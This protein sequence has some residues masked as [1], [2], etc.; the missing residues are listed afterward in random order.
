MT[1][2]VSDDKAPIIDGALNKLGINGF[3]LPGGTDKAS[4]H[5]YGPVYEALLKLMPLPKNV[6]EVGVFYGGSLLLWQ[7]VFPKAQIVGIDCANSIHP[8]VSDR[9]DG[10]RT[11]FLQGNAYEQT[12][13]EKVAEHVGGTID[14]AIDDGPHTLESQQRFL[15]LYGPLLAP[16]GIAIVED[17]VS[18]SWLPALQAQVPEGWKWQAIDLRDKKGRADDIMFVMQRPKGRKRQGKVS[19]QSLGLQEAAA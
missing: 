18:P 17:I 4:D 19:K 12:M 2:L 11:S 1:I 8:V 7:S 5:S 3:H 15:E 10:G 6:V 9:F 14:I 13:V 16:G